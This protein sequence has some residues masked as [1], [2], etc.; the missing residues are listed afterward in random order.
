MIYIFNLSTV[1][2]LRAIWAPS[3]HQLNAI[4]ASSEYHLCAIW[5]QIWAPSERHMST[6][7]V[8]SQRHLN[9]I[10]APSECH[11][12]VIWVPSK[13]HLI[14]IWVLSKRHLS[15]LWVINCHLILI[16]NFIT[17][18]KEDIP[19]F[20][21]WFFFMFW[22]VKNWCPDLYAFFLNAV[23]S[24]SSFL[25]LG[26]LSTQ[27]VVSNDEFGVQGAHLFYSIVRSKST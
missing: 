6:I 9:A 13:R 8:P 20:K 3:E 14:A 11:L 18:N 15:A 19:W 17:G 27:Q 21:V 26:P 5:E 25:F 1:C 4:W 24:F 16:L 12:S 22:C 10:L 7:Y 23:C 2:H